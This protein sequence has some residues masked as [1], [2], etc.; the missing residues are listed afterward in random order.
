MA[1]PLVR[2]LTQLT[3]EVLGVGKKVQFASPS[4]CGDESEALLSL[5]D[6]ISF[7]LLSQWARFKYELSSRVTCCL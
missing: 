6:G 5:C 3:R 4:L 1:L 7:N 2:C